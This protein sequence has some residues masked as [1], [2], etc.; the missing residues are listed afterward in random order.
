MLD[1]EELAKPG[2]EGAKY[3]CSPAL[4]T[5]EHREAL[6]TAIDRKWLNAVSSDHCG[7]DYQTQ[8]HMGAGDG[9]SFADIPNGAPSLQ[10]RLNLL[11]TYGVCAGKLSRT[12]LVDLF[13]TTPAKINGLTTKGHIEVGYDADLVVFDP[14]YTG[15]MSA[16]NNL[17]GVDYCP[18]EGFEQKG[19]CLLYT[20]RCV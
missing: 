14:E 9:K 17:E 18:F 11:W 16:K 7:F 4:R 12:R 13:S 19:R 20:S 3:V 2:F 1:T 10:N 6:W 8:K 15:V 5:K